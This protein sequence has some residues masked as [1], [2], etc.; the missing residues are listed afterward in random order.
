MENCEEWVDCSESNDRN[1]RTFS[2]PTVTAASTQGIGSSILRDDNSSFHDF[3]FGPLS[4]YLTI[5]DVHGF[6]CPGVRL[7]LIAPV[8][9]FYSVLLY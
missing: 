2:A 4:S 5:G 3:R 1:A 9:A 7:H 8:F 6:E